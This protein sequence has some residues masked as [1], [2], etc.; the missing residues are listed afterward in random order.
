[1]YRQHLAHRTRPLL[2]DLSSSLRLE[3]RDFT[4]VFVLVDAL[5][6][7]AEANGVRQSLLSELRGRMVEPKFHLMI[8]SRFMQALNTTRME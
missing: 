4:R 5:D 7:C 3:S 1:M 8:T 6:E 2:S